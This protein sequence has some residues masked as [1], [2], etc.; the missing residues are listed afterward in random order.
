MRVKSAL[1]FATV[2]LLLCVHAVSAN[3]RQ[4]NIHSRHLLHSEHDRF[5]EILAAAPSEGDGQGV[6]R[7][8]DAGAPLVNKDSIIKARTIE[9][10]DDKAADEVRTGLCCLVLACAATRTET[11]QYNVCY[12][13]SRGSWKY[14][15]SSILRC[16]VQN[17][18]V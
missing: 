6:W 13:H 16:K 8:N 17:N 7:Y 5:F 4:D 15:I 10:A 18:N 11:A 2:L 1:T 14:N 9:M 3:L 12:T